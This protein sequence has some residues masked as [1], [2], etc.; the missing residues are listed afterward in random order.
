MKRDRQ[1]KPT[2]GLMPTKL[3]TLDELKILPSVSVPREEKA[4]PIELPT[5][6]PEDEPLRSI[7]G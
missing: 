4:S 2:E 3:L 7:F 5:P 6:L 1:V